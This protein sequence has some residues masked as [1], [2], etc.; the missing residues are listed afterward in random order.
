MFIPSLNHDS[1]SADSRYWEKARVWAMGR[2]YV[3]AEATGDMDD[4]GE[5]TKGQGVAAPVSVSHGVDPFRQS[6]SLLA[7]AR[8]AR[9]GERRATFDFKEP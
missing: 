3:V 9:I 1:T 5:R 8:L 6:I 2:E 4:T 7:A